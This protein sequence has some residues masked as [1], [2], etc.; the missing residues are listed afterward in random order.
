MNLRTCF[1]LLLLS[2]VT[3]LCAGMEPNLR[4]HTY[5]TDD[6]L[7]QNTV[8]SIARDK[9]GFIWIGTWEGLNR[10]DGYSFRTFRA[11]PDNH[12]ALTNNRID[13]IVTDTKGDIWIATGDSSLLFRYNYTTEDFTAFAPHIVSSTVRRALQNYAS[14]KRH[15]TTKMEQW[16]ITAKGILQQNRFTSTEKYIRSTPSLPYPLSGKTLNVLYADKD[17]NLWV[18]TQNN[19]FA[20]SYL[21]NKAIGYLPFENDGSG[22]SVIRAVCQDRDGN[23]WAGTDADGVKYYSNGNKVNSLAGVC[24]PNVR[25]IL[26]DHTGLIWIGTKGGLDCYNPTLKRMTHFPANAP[27]SI[28]HP[29]VFSLTEDSKGNVWAGTYAGLARYDR[30]S[31]NFVCYPIKGMLKN[32]HV[33]FIL[34]DHRARLWIATEGGGLTCLQFS[35][36][37]GS[38]SF[39]ARHYLSEPGNPN[40]LINNMVLSLAEDATHHIWIGTNGG[41][42]RLN[43]ES[44][45]FD[46]F[47]VS[48]GFPDDLIMGLLCDK[49]GDLWVSHKKGLSRM[50]IRNLKYRTFTR[51]DGLQG[52]EFT[53]ACYRN[54]LTGELF[55]GGTNGLNRFFPAHFN[56]NLQKPT[57]VFC[58]LR[59]MNQTILPGMSLNDRI[60]CPQSLLTTRRITLGHN[61]PNFSI[62]FSALVYDNPEGCHYKYRLLP[63]DDEWIYT[64]ARLREAA[65]SHLPPGLYTLEVQAANSDG[66]WSD[67][68]ARIEIEILPPWW[69]TLWARLFYLLLVA[70]TGWMV[71]R[72]IRTRIEFRRQLLMEQLKTE[73][74]EELTNMKLQFFTEISHELRTPLTLIIDPLQQLLE[75]KADDQQTQYYYR[76]MNRNA[77]QLLELINQ[78]LDFR[79]IQSNKLV[80]Q[81]EPMELVEFVRQTALAFEHRA[82]NMHI[83]FSIKS[84]E[85]TIRLM[86]DADKMRKVLNNLLANA[87][88]FTPAYGK[89]S[90]NIFLSDDRKQVS[91]AVTDNGAGIAP[92]HL[93]KLFEP[94]YQVEEAPQ[95]SGGSGLGLALSRALIRLHGGDIR[96]ES[97]PGNGS[98]FSIILPATIAI[99]AVS[100]SAPATFDTCNPLQTTDYPTEANTEE[101][102]PLL[103]LIDDN[104]DIRDYIRIHFSREFRVLTAVNGL[105][106]YRT[107]LSEIPDL[108]ISDIMMPD[109]DGLALCRS[110]KTDE[111]TSH[112][113]VILLTA[114]QSDESRIEGYETGADAYITKPFNQQLLHTRVHNLLEQRQRLRTLYSEGTPQ[115]L[116]RISINN[117]DNSFLEKVVALVELQMENP[118]FD[119]DQLADAL[120]MSRSQLYRKIKA[121]T[122]R[123]VHDFILSLRMH[124]ARELLLANEFS[125]SE[126]AYKVGFTLPTNF[127]RSFNKQFG[128]T[129]TKFLEKYKK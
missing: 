10:F 5:N 63:F 107:A 92:E 26:C 53:Q 93:E 71:Y 68:S 120:R 33:R 7:S 34:E 49:E 59:V 58:S 4:F 128:L 30:T 96:V 66:V 27:G 84:T 76:L 89:I 54:P 101:T 104:D 9:Y 90:V 15:A 44:G 6:G 82:D 98:S 29:W 64:D 45:N 3:V 8:S 127:T 32:A 67:H 86:F 1:L 36:H 79:K 116:K 35:P 103:L 61:E 70:G 126:I 94:F 25:S 114:R 123:S 14:D 12:S 52:N 83:S 110:L 37:S 65:Y 51:Y 22:K 87:F 78:L 57:P 115:E 72:Y 39:I 46:R 20:V 62:E 125:I 60:V 50:D 109:M 73:K 11:A 28:R 105:E 118:D 19:G 117:T 111:R 16:S 85:P 121:L 55:F 17:S 24:N 88:R 41:L 97:Q 21:Y 47:S 112:I 74:N 113:P 56:L 91:I 81:P 43:P 48:N 106:G 124:K 77:S 40:S 129:P 100:D 99:E 18:G 2:I 108:I 80:V 119:T 42:C 102:S 75:G 31:G 69:Q 95:K 122:N 13:A 38:N 23:V